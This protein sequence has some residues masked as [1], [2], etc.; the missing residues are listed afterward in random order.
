MIVGIDASNLRQGGGRTHL[1]ELL[2]AAEPQRDEFTQVIVWGS[3]EVLSLLPDVTWLRRVHIS[4]AEGGLM[5][6]VAW[7][8]LLLPKAC[9]QA[10]CNI[11][12]APG[13]SVGGGFRPV[14]TM[15]RNTLPF[16]W[17]EL[18]RYGVTFFTLKQ[19]ILREVQRNSFKNADG[20][21]C[22]N[23]H[24]SDVLANWGVS[25]G[26][27]RA[28]IPHGIGQQFVKAPRRQRATSEFSNATPMRLLYVSNLHLYK[29][30]WIVA[31]AVA[32]LRDEGI[33]ITLTIIGPPERGLG[34]LHEVIER[35]DPQRE[36]LFYLGD[37]SYNRIH[38]EYAKVDIGVFAS[39]CENMPNIL[40]EKMAAGLP[41]A[42]SNRPPMPEILG[43]AGVTF[44][45]ENFNDVVNSMRKLIKSP[46]LRS[47]MAQAASERARAFSWERCSRD[48]FKFLAQV[49]RRQ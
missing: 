4:L 33:P 43:E 24:A 3:E 19:L 23:Q 15:F 22:L 10:G 49:Y 9:S 37:L 48:T 2:R 12:F 1:I 27:L 28:I 38:Q 34:K 45:P 31:E 16:D 30:H 40:L 35:L 41:I 32:Q 29:H 6:R 20:L 5:G 36:F 18:R 14:V 44:D 26:G 21:I 42:C 47:V 7:Q 39:T 11:L 25:G 13:G 8:F 46:E 17:N